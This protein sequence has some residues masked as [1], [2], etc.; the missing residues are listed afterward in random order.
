[1][2]GSDTPLGHAGEISPSPRYSGERDGVRGGNPPA[3]AV[4]RPCLGP[5]PY[6]GPRPFQTGETIY[7]RDAEIRDLFYLLN[8]ERI[9]VLYSPSGAGKTSL[10]QAGLIPLL[11]REAFDVW[12]VIRVSTPVG[13][14]RRTGPGATD[15]V[16][17]GSPDPAPVTTV[18]SPESGRPAVGGCGEVGRPAPSAC[19]PKRQRA[20][21]AFLSRA[22]RV[23]IA[24]RS[25]CTAAGIR[26]AGPRRVPLAGAA[27]S[28]K[29]SPA[30][31]SGP[32]V[33]RFG[34][35]DYSWLC[36]GPAGVVGGPLHPPIPETPVA[37]K[38]ASRSRPCLG[39]RLGQPTDV[40][41]SGQR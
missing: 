36:P 41:A 34:R 19:H 20:G 2:S 8:A 12:P 1:M 38:R 23:T 37:G 18:R 6:V 9:V 26:A 22:L 3:E 7:G 15:S 11:K 28:A 33:G 32:R 17:R 4:P 31:G 13:P 39:I 40:P 5:N 35:A 16:V 14:G 27:A 10:V 24:G 21:A 30:Q 29:A 25:P